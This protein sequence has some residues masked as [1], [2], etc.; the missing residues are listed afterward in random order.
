[1]VRYAV[2]R[3]RKRDGM[4]SSE[5]R[6]G[7]KGNEG[8]KEIAIDTKPHSSHLTFFLNATQISHSARS[9]ICDRKRFG[10]L[11]TRLGN[12]MR[13]S[14]FQEQFFTRIFFFTNNARVRVISSKGKT[15][16]QTG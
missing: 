1:M 14:Q 15:D 3:D 11:G 7:K 12:C 9:Q 4:T 6:R 10:H 2:D 13:I 8:G 5:R 16:S